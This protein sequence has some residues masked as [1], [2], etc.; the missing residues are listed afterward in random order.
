MIVLENIIFIWKERRWYYN[1]LIII[2]LWGSRVD[3]E[4]SIKRCLRQK[5]YAPC[6][7]S[8]ALKNTHLKSYILIENWSV[9]RLQNN[10]QKTATCLCKR[11]WL[12]TYY[13]A[14]RHRLRLRIQR[15]SVNILK[16]II[17]Q[18][19]KSHENK[20]YYINNVVVVW[21]SCIN[22]RGS[23]GKG[24]LNKHS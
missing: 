2:F 13:R 9:T 21:E 3:S 14:A 23:T 1:I 17:I 24:V 20:Q 5:C 4:C 18:W 15:W 7:T 8:T 19:G 10:L 22:C 6:K 11:Y 12:S 16:K